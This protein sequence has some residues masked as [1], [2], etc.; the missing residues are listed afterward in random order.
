MTTM[1]CLIHRVE[2]GVAVFDDRKPDDWFEDCP[3]CVRERNN[4]MYNERNALI[5]ERGVLIDAMRTIRT[6]IEVKP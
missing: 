1:R 5:A 6:V 4:T 3:V 2:W